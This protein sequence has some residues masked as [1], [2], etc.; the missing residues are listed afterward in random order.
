MTV[1]RGGVLTND[2]NDVSEK[3]QLE[4]SILYNSIQIQNVNKAN[5]EQI[6]KL[7]QGMESCGAIADNLSIVLNCDI[8]FH[9]VEYQIN[10][11]KRNKSFGF[12][13]IP[14]E[15]L[16]HPDCITALYYLFKLCF[17]HCLVPSQWLKA[18]ISPVPKGADKD[19]Y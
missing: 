17:D 8:S 13:Q 10:K 2:K 18:V 1:Y 7:N 4:F 3:W 16:Q 5:L 12:D 11:A 9:E 15:V 14:N 19:P 6:K